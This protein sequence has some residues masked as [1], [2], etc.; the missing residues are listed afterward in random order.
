[1]GPKAGYRGTTGKLKK[2]VYL[3]LIEK[4]IQQQVR[5]SVK[6]KESKKEAS[7]LS[8]TSKCRQKNYGW[9]LQLSST[10]D[11]LDN[12]SLWWAVYILGG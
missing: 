2:A 12:F 5:S 3:V 11:S 1:M 10:T 4:K 6:A 9:T 8:K 7:M